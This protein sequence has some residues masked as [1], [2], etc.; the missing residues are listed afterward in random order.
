MDKEKLLKD[1]LESQ[2]KLNPEDTA[3]ILYDLVLTLSGLQVFLR[4]NFPEVEK[5][6]RPF[7]LILRADGEPTKYLLTIADDIME[8]ERKRTAIY[9]TEK[10]K[11]GKDNIIPFPKHLSQTE[12]D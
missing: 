6:I 2:S 8:K 4:E 5:I 10:D 9:N 12:K 1:L 11:K 7:S 3:R